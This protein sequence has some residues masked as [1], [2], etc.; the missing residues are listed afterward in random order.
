M[1][2]QRQILRR[3]LRAQQGQCVVMF[4]AAHVDQ[5]VGALLCLRHDAIEQG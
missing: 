5:R 3:K 4:L 2:L 1:C